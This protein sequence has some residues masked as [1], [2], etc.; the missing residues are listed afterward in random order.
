[1]KVARK[2]KQPQ[3]TIPRMELLLDAL[4]TV[5]PA[6]S[7]LTTKI[8]PFLKIPSSLLGLFTIAE[9]IGKLS[10]K[11]QHLAKPLNLDIDDLIT[12]AAAVCSID[13]N[14]SLR[15]DPYLSK[16]IQKSGYLQ[17]P[18]HGLYDDHPIWC[19]LWFSHWSSGK[20]I[21]EV[22]GD[23]D[24]DVWGGACRI[25]FDIPELFDWMQ[26]NLLVA[27]ICITEKKKLLSSRKRP[28]EAS[29][30]IR[31]MHQPQFQWFFYRTGHACETPAKLQHRLISYRAER[32]IPS[33]HKQMF[34]ALAEMLGYAHGLKIN[35]F[36]DV[37][38]KKRRGGG[39]QVKRGG[40]EKIYSD[41]AA[42]WYFLDNDLIFP[43][44][45]SH[46]SQY[47][48][49]KPSKS[50]RDKLNRA[51]I[52]EG[53][54]QTNGELSVGV[55]SLYSEGGRD[56]DELPPLQS[57]YASARARARA[58]S[59]DN[60]R[61]KNRLGRI[62]RGQLRRIFIALSELYQSNSRSKLG[63]LGSLNGMQVRL[64]SMLELAALML[65]TGSPP[66]HAHKMTVASGVSELPDKY[67]LAYSRAH[68][69]WIRPY[70]GATR[71]PLASACKA[72]SEETWP[73][74]IFPDLFGVG[75]RIAEVFVKGQF[76]VRPSACSHL[77][78]THVKPVL[79]RAGVEQRWCEWESVGNILP[80]WFMGL[81][82]GDHL[83]TAL[84]FGLDDPLAATH[85]Y[86]TALSRDALAN[87]YIAEVMALWGSLELPE[88]VLNGR[89]LSLPNLD[90]INV[91]E[92][93]VGDD[94]V[95]KIDVVTG[96]L[97]TIRNEIAHENDGLIDEIVNNHNRISLYTALGLAI[98]TGFRS[99]RTPIANLRSIHHDTQTL[100]L[101]EKD[102][103]D[104]VHGR[105]VVL[106]ND[107]YEQVRRYLSHLS[108]FFDE[109]R[110]DI[111][112]A[113]CVKATKHR[114][115]S[116]Y[117]QGDFTLDLK[118]TLFLIEKSEKGD[119]WVPVEMTGSRMHEMC[120]DHMPGGWPVAN[121]GR[122]MLRTFLAN[123]G[124]PLT[125]VNA[126]MGHWYYGEEPWTANSSM[127]PVIYRRTIVPYLDKLLARVGYRVLGKP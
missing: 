52:D 13:E 10:G 100:C 15:S 32:R 39:V 125:V 36:R 118:S 126:V 92:S 82:E 11:L 66:D 106:P 120:N 37:T 41:H 76:P 25:D 67:T 26:A 117:N 30:L 90:R 21:E 53:E 28:Y 70:Y 114:D 29:L 23:H 55:H 127:D 22:D 111:P 116:R 94:R 102:R 7:D 115:I 47:R 91:V 78:N 58:V 62:R 107:I 6:H 121:A 42:Y 65:V 74:V 109:R 60:Q 69:I 88:S 97:A 98:V 18:L 89:L 24:H 35:I 34:G 8:S 110:L 93:L 96:L 124:C 122:H 40:M 71:N 84:L 68:S 5:L 64:K 46:S 99:V 73:R 83:R 56:V 45:I 85:H 31:N 3:S 112:A 54:Y 80:S 75:G 33:R 113:L 12:W 57:L 27:F 123:E 14:H 101:Q 1:M 87:Y 105:V 63:R 72:Y 19:A 104:G 86:Y 59:M 4:K 51:G 108:R 43:N 79:L 20:E 38:R 48:T 9:R 77:W 50:I 16:A 61:F 81:E 119:G 103:S 17:P 2:S 44:N 95:P 49:N